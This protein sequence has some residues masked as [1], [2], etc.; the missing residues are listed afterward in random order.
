MKARICSLLILFST[1]VAS[2]ESCLP[3]DIGIGADDDKAE[4]LFYTGT[5]HYRNEDY[6][7]SVKY[8]SELSAIEKVAPEYEELQ[9]NVLNN[10]GYMKF[11]GFGTPED[12]ATAMQHWKKAVSL[13]HDEAEFHL[14]H[15]YADE[16]EATYNLARA[17]KHC[18][19]ALVIY[20]GKEDPD[21]E[22]LQSIRH[23]NSIVN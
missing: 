1:T 7:L 20:E 16:K 12:K 9:I 23:Y 21:E 6:E 5:C 4:F 8:W 17:K 18:H 13:G 10:L 14:C 19:R 15:A 11:F 22:T 3:E 2:K